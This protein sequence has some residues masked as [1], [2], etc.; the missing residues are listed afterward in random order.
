[1]SGCHFGN[2]DSLVGMREH[3]RPLG[4]AVVGCGY[5]G[6]KHVRVLHGIQDVR[7]LVIIDSD[8]RVRDAMLSAFPG[9][10]AFSSLEAALP[11]VDAVI[12]ATPPQTHA[13]LALKALR[14]GKHVLVEK[15]LTRSPAESQILVDEASY[16]HK[17]LMVGHIFLFNPAIRELRRRLANGDLGT[18]HYIYSSRLNLGPVRRDVNVVWDLA[19]HDITIANYLLQEVP[20]AVSAWGASFGDQ[21]VEDVAYIRLHYEQLGVSAYSHISWLNPTKARTLTVVGDLRM[22]V[23]D[24]LA[25]EPLRIYDRGVEGFNDRVP[26]Y[27]R[28]LSYRYGDT[29]SPHIGAGEPLAVQDRHF[30]DCIRSGN[31]PESDGMSGLSVVTV[32]DAIG[33]AMQQAASVDVHYSRCSKEASGS[34]LQ[35]GA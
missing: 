13:A 34:W 12:I 29:L 25:D 19:P 9:V 2:H 26:P 16:C 8:T 33:R 35:A 10:R 32:L 11:L 14:S 22:A 23:Y 17:I 4:I 5:W 3:N 21:R 15:P 24:D 18:I 27:N 1:M 30:I 7:E 28:P 20:T 6:S 31:V